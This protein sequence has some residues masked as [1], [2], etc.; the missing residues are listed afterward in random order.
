MS[1]RPKSYRL[2]HSHPRSRRMQCPYPASHPAQSRE[3]GPGTTTSSGDMGAVATTD[4]RRHLLD[5]QSRIIGASLPECS[6]DNMC[7]LSGLSG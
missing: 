4:M 7:A 3:Q 1:L 6:P 5:G 2:V